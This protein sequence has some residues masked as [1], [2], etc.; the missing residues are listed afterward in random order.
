MAMAAMERTAS[1]RSHPTPLARELTE[2]SPPTAEE[3]AFGHTLVQRHAAIFPVILLLKC[4]QYLGYCPALSAIP[5]AIVNHVRVC[6]R[7]PAH[8]EPLT[9]PP[10]TLRRHERAIRTYLG[11]QPGHSHAAR[12]LAIAIVAEAARVMAQ[13]ADLMNVAVGQVRR[14]PLEFPKFPKL[15]RE[16]QL[17]RAVGP[18]PP[19]RLAWRELAPA[20]QARPASLVPAPR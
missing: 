11:L 2:Y 10:R 6:L 8:L 15:D 9:P 4:A 17:G 14:P 1:P 5:S 20:P 7:L 18:R 13:P 16:R 12:R 3:I 19:F